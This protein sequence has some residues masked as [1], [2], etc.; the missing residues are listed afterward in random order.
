MLRFNGESTKFNAFWQ[1]F[2]CAIHGN[3]SVP[4]VNKLNYLLSL[5]KGPAYRALDGL[6]LQAENYDAAVEILTTCFGKK[7]SIINA[8]MNALL[9]L[10]E[11]LNESTDQLRKS[12]DTINVHVRGLDSMGMSPESYGPPFSHVGI[13]FACPVMVKNTEGDREQKVYV[14]VFTCASTRAVHLYFCI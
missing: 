11:H 8:H 13:D 10:K 1:S 4:R 2:E 12:Y 7:Q 5:L 6:S 3:S 9:K 14:C